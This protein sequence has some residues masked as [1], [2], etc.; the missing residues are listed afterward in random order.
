MSNELV[1]R[2][3]QAQVDTLKNLGMEEDQRREFIGNLGTLILNHPNIANLEKNSVFNVA[4][5]MTKLNVSVE[6]STA[7]MVPYNNKKKGTTEAQLQI[8]YKGYV[9]L[10]MRTGLYKKIDCIE[11]KE[12]DYVDFNIDTNTYTWREGELSFNEVLER[13]KEKTIGYRAFAITNDGYKIERFMTLEEIEAH[14]KK[15]SKAYQYKDSFGNVF[16]T[17]KDEMDRKVVIKMLATKDLVKTIKPSK[18]RDLIDAIKYDSSV[19]GNDGKP[20]Y[21]DNPNDPSNKRV[22]QISKETLEDGTTIVHKVNQNGDKDYTI[23]KGENSS[24]VDTFNGK[25]F[26]ITKKTDNINGGQSETIDPKLSQEKLD[27]IKF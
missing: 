7:Y 1:F 11:V 10:A 8:G 17:S 19:I 23:E 12:S 14:H 9:E 22:K 15:W 21:I 20:H 5:A 2:P 26:E 3:T 13:K 27:K 4:L 18:G 24:S 25:G 16:N 6:N